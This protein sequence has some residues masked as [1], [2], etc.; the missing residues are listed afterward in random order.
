MAAEIM[1]IKMEDID[2]DHPLFRR[3]NQEA[4]ISQLASSIERH[5][6]HQPIDVVRAGERF[7]IVNGNR[8]Y[9]ALKE[10][11]RQTIQ[12]RVLPQA[13]VRTAVMV[14][15]THEPL[16]TWSKYDAI[17]RFIEEHPDASS[18]EVEDEICLDV[19]LPV[20]EICKYIR[21]AKSH[22]DVA[23]AVRRGSKSND[24]TG[25][26]LSVARELAYRP[27]EEQP[28][29]LTRVFARQAKLERQLKRPEFF[30]IADEMAAP[31][32]R[33]EQLERLTASLSK[34]AGAAIRLRCRTGKAGLSL[35]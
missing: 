27:E 30:D 34:V 2:S 17:A 10:L 19:M 7:R 24:V 23:G 11:K 31:Q 20:T 33:K 5:G 18:T 15:A 1:E 14:N 26:S 21:I 12:A 25:I 13:T 9:L 29:L 22:P 3:H 16:D 35:R 4:N 28:Q 6:L 8:R 32:S